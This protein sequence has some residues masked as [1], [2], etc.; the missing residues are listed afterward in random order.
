[1]QVTVNYLDDFNH[2]RQ[3]TETLVVQVEAQPTP[4]PEGQAGAEGAGPGGLWA[5]ALKILKGLLGL[6]S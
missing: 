1:L 2:P 3:V 5:T 4:E 6:G